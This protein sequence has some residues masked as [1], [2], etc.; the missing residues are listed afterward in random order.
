M[1]KKVSIII[2]AYNEEKTILNVLDEVKRLNINKEIIIVDDGSTDK[3]AKLL[4]K[5]KKIKFIRHG[6][7]M[8]RGAAVRTGISVASGDIIYIQDA[9]MEQFPSDIPK[10]VEP[11]L[12]E[13]SDVVYG[14]RLSNPVG[15]SFTHK[16]GNK[17]IAFVGMVLFRQRLTDIYTG[18]KC[19][20]SEIIKSLD[21]ESNGFEQEAELL[22]KLSENKMRIKEV[23]INYKYRNDGISNM[24]M[25]DGLNGI[26][27]MLKY[28]FRKYR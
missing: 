15:M 14:N 18:S 17:I 3:T 9:D 28:F 2:P 16:I 22:A 11:I 10:L 20:R 23:N 1:N 12:N 24:K 7:N 4:E 6:K 25:K 21:L 27:T 19:Y 13:K 8:G 5:E 26:F